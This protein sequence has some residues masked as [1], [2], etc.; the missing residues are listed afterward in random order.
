MD[1]TLKVLF[2]NA[3]DAFYRIRKYKVGDFFGPVDLGL[4]LAGRYKSL[5][6]G[7]GLLSGSIFPGSNRLIFTG[8]SPCWGGFYISSMGGAGLVFDNLGI[9][10]LSIVGKAPVPSVLYLNRVHGEEIQVEIAPLDLNRIWYEGRGGIY[11]LM[12]YVF[13]QYRPRYE[14][15]PRIL[16]TGPAAMVTDF[17]GVAS[18][19]VKRGAL[20]NVDTWAGRGGFGSALLQEHGIAAV[21]YGGTHIDED[22]RDRKVADEWFENRYARKLAAKDLEITTKYRFDPNFDT[23]GTFGVNYATMGSKLLAFNYQSMN[24]S[25]ELR[26]KLQKE[27]ILDHYLKQF[28]EETIK[29]RQQA[30][31]GEPCAAVCKKLRDEYKKDYE[32]YQ[33]MGPLSGIFDQRAAEKL[34]HHADML[35]FDAISVGGVISWLMECLDAGELQPAD[36]GVSAKPVFNPQNFDIVKDSMHNA[37]LGCEILDSIIA[38]TINLKEGARKY[39]R[40]LSRAKG[41]NLLNRFVYTAYARKGWMVPNQYW[42]P[43]ALSPMAIMG[44]YY[45]YYGD[46]FVSP[47]ELGRVNAQRML[48]ELIIDNMG[49]CR[50]HRLWAEEMVPEIVES[51]Y[52]LGEKFMESIRF[53]ASRING[54]NSSVF[55]ESER[56]FEYIA[57]FLRRKKEEGLDSEEF[58]KWL[59]AF[60]AIPKEAALDFWY[61][62]HKGVQESLR[63]FN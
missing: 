6:I 1:S 19:P 11:S 25:K 38:G 44:K 33:T 26:Q 17:G 56:N 48:A 52:G 22:F 63:E 42:T 20:S 9:N 24:W 57:S 7:V 58:N 21:I 30:T 31:C 53:T 8:F 55:W 54:R 12:D 41:V 4:H 10:M 51:L 32:P 14:N 35:G 43:G 5:N 47:R 62:I 45:M 18:V 61:E 2:V 39:G 27:F 46:E 37:L 59:D 23:G 49:I 15:E 34:N 13:E 60:E 50:F 36:L 28:N 16:A 3:T 29:T 40:R